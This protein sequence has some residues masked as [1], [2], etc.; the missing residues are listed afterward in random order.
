M[1][2]N[3]QTVLQRKKSWAKPELQ[4]LDIRDTNYWEYKFNPDTGFWQEVWV[5]ES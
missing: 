1:E 2:L 5:N 4:S 3:E